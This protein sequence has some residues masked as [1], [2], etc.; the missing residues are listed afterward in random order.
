MAVEERTTVPT[1]ATSDEFEIVSWEHVE[2]NI[3]RV[4]TRSKKYGVV[5][6][7][8]LVMPDSVFRL[9]LDPPK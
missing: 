4:T 5:T 1:M 9:D 3:Y 7:T 2:K 8:V 6:Q